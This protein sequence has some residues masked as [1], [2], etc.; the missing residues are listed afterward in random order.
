[1][2]R[3]ETVGRTRTLD[4]RLR[5][6]GFSWGWWGRRRVPREGDPHGH[7]AGVVAVVTRR[8]G[9]LE[10]A[11]GSPDVRVN[12]RVQV[13]PA[14]RTRPSGGLRRAPVPADM[15]GPRP[16]ARSGVSEQRLSVRRDPG[17]RPPQRLLRLCGSWIRRLNLPL[18][19]RAP[20][21]ARIRDAGPWAE[22][23]PAENRHH[24]PRPPARR[25]AWER[26]AWRSA[27]APGTCWRSSS[28]GD[29]AGASGAV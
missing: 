10:R 17:V 15:A 26:R 19:D 2:G 3:G 8:R 23:M 1:M 9:H 22:E 27:A 24:H 28:G 6:A 5:D 21:D 13:P 7:R 18:A 11:G 4:R 20:I 12:P 16:P 14:R 25:S 29:G